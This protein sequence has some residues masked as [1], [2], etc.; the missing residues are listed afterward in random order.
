MI[1]AI[2]GDIIGSVHE[3]KAMKSTEFDLFVNDCTFTDDTVMTIAVADSILR[4][5]DYVPSF[6]TFGRKHPSAGY[7]GNFF[8]WLHSARTEPYFSFG[9]G[10]AM[11]VSP[12]GFAFNS[13]DE[14]LKEAKRSAEVTHNHPEGI[15]GAQA[16]A[17][18]IFLSRQGESKDTIKA[19]LAGRF[20]YNFNRTLAEIRPRYHFD[21]TCQGSVS[22]SIISFLESQD[23]E[24]AVRNAISLGGDSD[25]M[26]CI[27]GGIAQAFYRHIPPSI[28]E[29]TKRR[30]TAE[31]LGIV[32]DFESHFASAK[33]Y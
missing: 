14:I 7:G 9:N 17:L 19:E 13:V 20:G 30:L 22:E 1:G 11:R 21:E 2:A 24:S 4:G 32:S 29:E 3:F 26:A 25:T 6:K 15:K 12:V 27:A 28:V 10:S 18:A 33:N 5:T 16:V 31:L 8:D 23:Y